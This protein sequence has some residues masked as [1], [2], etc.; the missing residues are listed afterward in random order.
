MLNDKLLANE[1]IEYYQVIFDKDTIL[2]QITDCN[3]SVIL[4]NLHKLRL[5]DVQ[6][7]YDIISI[8]NYDYKLNHGLNVFRNT[9]SYVNNRLVSSSHGKIVSYSPNSITILSNG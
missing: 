2:N 5:S 4:N 6:N 3:Q 8:E 7:I 1:T 9:K